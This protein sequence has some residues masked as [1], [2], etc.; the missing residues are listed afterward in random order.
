MTAF[1]AWW[2]FSQGDRTV[3]ELVQSFFFFF[4]FF[5]KLH[6]AAQVFVMADSVREMDVKKSCKSGKFELFEQL[7][8]LL[9]FAGVPDGSI[10]KMF[11]ATQT[12]FV[13]LGDALKS[14]ITFFEV[15]TDVNFD[16]EVSMFYVCVGVWMDIRQNAFY[17]GW[18]EVWRAQ[19]LLCIQQFVISLVV[20]SH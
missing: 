8:F 1:A 20:R 6:E 18:E 9:V 14:K 10:D 19:V 7:H 3:L 5:V 15:T 4:F 13:Q 16:V 17:D 2:G 12:E 11:P